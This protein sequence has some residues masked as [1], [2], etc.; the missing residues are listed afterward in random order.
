MTWNVENLFRAGQPGGPTAASVYEKKLKGLA[1]TINDQVPDAV[2]VQEVGD[3]AALDDLVA[4][5]NG[6]WQAQV[7]TR[8][9]SR[10][11][12]V[13]WLTTRPITVSQEIVDFPALLPPVQVDDEGTTLRRMGRG[14]LAINVT[15]DAG[16]AIRLVTCHLK[17]ELLTFPGGRF[18]PRDEDERARYAAYALVR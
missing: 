13:A 5:L 8:P 16:V 1:D 10:G 11:I 9:D 4:L 7:S 17:S 14:A 2:A 18:N 12:R 3:P 15:S 6:S